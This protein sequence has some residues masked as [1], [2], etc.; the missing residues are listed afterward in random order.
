MEE[1]LPYDQGTCLTIK[2]LSLTLPDF[3]VNTDNWLNLY[4]LILI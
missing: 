2:V 1:D 4:K 3:H